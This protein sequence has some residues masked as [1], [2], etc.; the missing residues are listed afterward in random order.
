MCSIFFDFKK[1]LDSVDHEILFKKLYH[2]G[3]RSPAFNLQQLG[4]AAAQNDWEGQ[5]QKKDW[6]IFLEELIKKMP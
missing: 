2:I 5:N 3:I 1:A 4:T 6:R